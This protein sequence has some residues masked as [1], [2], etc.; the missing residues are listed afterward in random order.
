MAWRPGITDRRFPEFSIT[1]TD[2]KYG[3][4]FGYCEIAYWGYSSIAGIGPLGDK[5]NVPNA[6]AI[7]DARKMAILAAA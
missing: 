4:Q 7:R 5:I 1:P 2:R 3:A 6:P